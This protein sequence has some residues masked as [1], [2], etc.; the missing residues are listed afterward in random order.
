[1]ITPVLGYAITNGQKLQLIGEKE[2]GSSYGFAV[3]KGQ[4]PEL[5][6]QFNAGLKKLKENGTYD[7]IVAK[8]ISSGAEDDDAEMTKIEPK[9]D[10]YS[11]ASDSTFAPFEFQNADGKYE[12]IDVDL[13]TRIAELQGFTIEFKFIGFSSAVQAVESGQADGMIAG[14]THYR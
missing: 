2:T 13:M 10:V 12:G 9:K 14:M 1:M 8:Y 3:K 4:N 11:I 5:I 6:K 7:K